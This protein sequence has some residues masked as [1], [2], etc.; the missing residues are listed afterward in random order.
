MPIPPHPLLR[1]AFAVLLSLA[2]LALFTN[3]GPARAAEAASPP[4]VDTS[5]LPA[6][7]ETWHA[8]NPYRGDPAAI[9][10]GRSAYNQACARCHGIDAEHQGNAAD[11]RRVDAYCRRIADAALRHACMLDNDAFFKDS[12]LHGKRRV[13]VEHMPPWAGVLSQELVWAI[14]AFVESRA[15]R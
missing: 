5:T 14:Q 7:G 12:V 2:A 1:A 8:S 9:A 15:P 4:T 13:G 3:A 11:L 6:L 10:I